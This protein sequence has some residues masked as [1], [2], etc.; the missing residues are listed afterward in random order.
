MICGYL[1]ADL[2]EVLDSPRKRGI[3]G[4]SRRKIKYVEKVAKE[5]DVDAY[6]WILKASDSD[7]GIK[8][9]P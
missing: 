7:Y 4:F 8:K 2:I 5:E 9:A 1:Q 3:V 6:I